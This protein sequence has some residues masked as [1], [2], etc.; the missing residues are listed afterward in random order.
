MQPIPD[1]DS[2]TTTTLEMNLIPRVP[3]HI[4]AE[5][6]SALWAAIADGGLPDRVKGRLLEQINFRVAEAGKGQPQPQSVV[7]G[8][9]VVFNGAQP[10]EVMRGLKALADQR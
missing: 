8:G 7:A 1:N 5:Q 3:E 2:P 4:S 9:G 6:A 10:D